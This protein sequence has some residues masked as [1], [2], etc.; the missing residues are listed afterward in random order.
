MLSLKEISDEMLALKEWSIEGD[1]IVKS[2][3]FTNFKEALD[4]I[5]KVGE[6][7]EKHAHHPGIILD[8]N[9]VRLSLTTHSEKGLTK[10][11]FELAREI[12]VI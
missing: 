5:N 6:I 9:L 1:M 2:F 4:F 10:K 11:D 8:Y 3:N 12:D 7:A